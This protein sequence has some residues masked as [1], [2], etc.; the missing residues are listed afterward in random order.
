MSPRISQHVSPRPQFTLKQIARSEADARVLVAAS[1]L[2]KRFSLQF[3]VFTEFT[4]DMLAQL[5]ASGSDVDSDVSEILDRSPAGIDHW[6]K[7]LGVLANAKTLTPGDRALYFAALLSIYQQ[8]SYHAVESRGDVK[9]LFVGIE[10]EG[11][12]LAE[13]LGWLPPGHSLAPHAKRIR[14]DSGLLVGTCGVDVHGD[15]DECVLVDGAIASGATLI[16]VMESIRQR[17]DCDLYRVLSV[18]GTIEALRAL[19]RYSSAKGLKLLVDVG[20]TTSGLNRDFYAVEEDGATK[21]VGDLGDIIAP[22]W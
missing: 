3:D 7:V 2:E 10:R 13:S 8:L 14:N 20:Y 4:Y 15:F 1:R 5:H 18:H 17:T 12:I 19:V 21:V 6:K 22:L 11:R 16:G 9:T